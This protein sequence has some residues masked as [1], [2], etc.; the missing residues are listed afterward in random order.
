MKRCPQCKRV[1]T[2]DA[3]VFCRVDGAALVSDSASLNSEAGTA[4]LNSASA[5]TEIETSV[6]PHTTDAAVN[7]ASAP[8]AALPAALTGTTGAPAKHKR[9]S[10]IT[11]AIIADAA[12]LRFDARAHLI[13]FRIRIFQVGG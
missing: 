1:E 11:I 2:D 8:T 12:E 10:A 3:L 7:R 5:A 4:K 6:L 13:G 9:R